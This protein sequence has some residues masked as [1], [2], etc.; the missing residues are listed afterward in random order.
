[1]NTAAMASPGVACPSCGAT[2]AGDYCSACGQRAP[3]A[4]DFS[5]K[6]FSHS[7]WQE[8]SGSD[9]R[10]W[11]TALGVFRPGVL[12]LAFLQFR[13]RQYLPPLR[14]YLLMSA[15]FFLLAWGV[16]FQLQLI[17]VRDAP[18]SAIPAALRALYADPATADRLS[19]WS[20]GYR[21]AGVL[22]L[23]LLVALLHWRK[24]LPIGR[25][26]VFATHYYCADYAIFLLAAP[27]LYFAPASA[28]KPVTQAV[29]LGGMA[30]LAW[31]AV[32][33]D[34]RVY[35]GRWLGNLLRGLLIVCADAAISVI[36]GQLA[37][38]SVLLT[39]P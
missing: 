32:V 3:Q 1:M 4:G 2:L 30:W 13:W 14:L 26:L 20:A 38:L 33:A 5:W 28:L 7:A 19:D 21:F 24:R 12:T 17:E 9:S 34:R 37:V 6:S 23:G 31:W 22:V 16:Y 18:A 29:T 11:R 8:L 35:G 36:A 39:R 15:A 27:L 10:L 25:H